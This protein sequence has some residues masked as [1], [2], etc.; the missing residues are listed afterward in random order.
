MDSTSFVNTCQCIKEALNHG[1]ME[2]VET[3]R[4]E[5]QLMEETQDHT[6]SISSPEAP[7]FKQNYIEQL[8]LLGD[9]PEETP[10]AAV[11]ACSD[12][13]VPVLD[14]FNQP[15][16]QVFEIQLTGNVASV[17]CLGSLAYAVEHLPTVEGVVV[18]GHT[19]CG[20]VTAA[21]DQFLS[22]KPET[23][24]ADSSIRSLINSITPSVEIAASALGKSSQFRS[25]GV[26][27]FSLDRGKLIDTA[28]F[29]NAAAMAWK[30]REFVNKLKRIVPVWYGVYD[31]ASCR[32]LHVDLERRD[33]SLL[34]GL[35]NAPGVIDLD[36][37]ASSMV[38][39]LSKMDNFDAA[40]FST[41][42]L[43]PQAKSVWEALSTGSRASK[44]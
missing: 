32:I 13:R 4:C 2:F 27:R 37:I 35:G 8:G 38:Q 33:G 6:D 1:N 17:E 25:G 26:P 10:K 14:V 36:D 34:F 3:L 19:G 22:P 12:A 5:Q 7:A 41:K 30:I 21:V 43:G 9:T 18:L 15:P 40:R 29:V 44:S 31:L 23:T 20:A 24:P 11:L 39:Y 16:N 28:I 42:S